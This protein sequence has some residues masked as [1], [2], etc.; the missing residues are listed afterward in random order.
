M[1]RLGTVLHLSVHHNLIIRGDKMESPEPFKSLPK[2]NSV[3]V[4]KSVKQIGK[5]SGIFGPVDHPYISVK[6]F[7]RISESE[8]RSQLSERL[9][10]L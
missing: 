2:I 4:N 5:V 7:K 3:V 6:A 9:Y 10:I 1:K 8:L